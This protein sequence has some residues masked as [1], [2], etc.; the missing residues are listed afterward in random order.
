MATAI[1]D[2]HR[3]LLQAQ[4]ATLVTQGADGHPQVTEVWFLADGDQLKL[5][6]S[7]ARQKVKNLL[8]D[9]ACALLLLDVGNPY[10]YLEV[11]ADAE[12]TPDPERTFAAR[13]WA[14]SGTDLSA[15]D[16]PEDKRVVVTLHPTRVNAVDMGV[17]G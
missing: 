6:L 1:P 7:T 12:L 2:S 8:R 11:R 13:V 14:K 9:P 16:W 15:W 17:G 10:R 4:F 5:S 3:D